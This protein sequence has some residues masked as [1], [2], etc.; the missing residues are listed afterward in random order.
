MAIEV[1]NMVLEQL[2][3][4]R[5]EVRDSSR[6]TVAVMETVKHTMEVFARLNERLDTMDLRLQRIGQDVLHLEIQNTGRHGETLHL[7]SQLKDVVEQMN[8]KLDAM[9]ELFVQG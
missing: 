4:L 8:D 9:R 2:R 5:E 7:G 1:D 6:Q 3:R